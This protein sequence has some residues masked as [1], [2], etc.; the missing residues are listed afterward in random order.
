MDCKHERGGA[1]VL[2]F[3]GAEAA[4]L[5]NLLLQ[6]AVRF[7]AANA[8]TSVLNAVG[9]PV[10]QKVARRAANEKRAR[11]AHTLAQMLEE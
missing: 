8:G 5:R 11:L 6:A 1:V 4:G 3:T 10:P 9:N 2:T 7:M